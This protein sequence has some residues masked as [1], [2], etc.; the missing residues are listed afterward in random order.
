MNEPDIR[1]FKLMNGE[2]IIA[3]VNK[4]DDTGF[5]LEI[6]FEIHK[7]SESNTAEFSLWMHMT[8]FT[9]NV[10]VQK[11]NIIG[12]GDANSVFKYQYIQM[13]TRLTEDSNDYDNP[14]AV[15][16]LNDDSTEEEEREEICVR[17]QGGPTVH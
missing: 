11:C 4:E 2:S 16:E 1:Q 5:M 3:Y 8:D 6:P 7:N 12:Y 13:M 15:I 10:Y 14:P 9:D 17:P